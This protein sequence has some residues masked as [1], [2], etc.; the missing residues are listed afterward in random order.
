LHGRIKG[1]WEGV[2]TC[3]KVQERKRKKGRKR[4]RKRERE[5]DEKRMRR[6]LEEDEKRMRRVQGRGDRTANAR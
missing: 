3:P 6:G 1:N 5:E 4:G 2:R